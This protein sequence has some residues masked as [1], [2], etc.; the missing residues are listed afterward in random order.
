M[1]LSKFLFVGVC[2]VAL[3]CSAGLAGPAL[4]KG[5]AA[6]VFSLTGSDGET[7]ALADFAG[8]QAVVVAWFPMA[9][10]GG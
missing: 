1:K 3:A 10:T 9:L 5:D 6:P 4:E 2:A 8:K 7:Y